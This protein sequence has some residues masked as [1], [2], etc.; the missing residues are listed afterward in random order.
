M[1]RL[2]LPA[3]TEM[4]IADWNDYIKFWLIIFP[5]SRTAPATTKPRKVTK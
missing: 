2:P 3:D 5:G 1:N 4:H